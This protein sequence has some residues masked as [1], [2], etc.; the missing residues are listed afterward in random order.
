ML[1]ATA[2]VIPLFK[3][4]NTSPIVG[5][6]LT[7]TLLGPSGLNWVRD[8]HRVDMLGELGIVFFLF[9]MGLEL[10][11]DRLKLMRKDVFGLGTSQ[12]AVT[13]LVGTLIGLY[14]GLSPAAAVTIGGSLALSSS[15]FVLQLLKDKGEMGTRHGRASF[16]ILLLQ[17]LAVVPL[18]IVVELLSKGGAGLGKALGLA[19]IKGC[20]A[21]TTMSYLGRRLLNP[22]FSQVAKSNSQ[23]AFLSIIL[24]TVLLMSFIT[25]GIGL[26][27]TLGAFLAGLLL[28]ETSYKYQIES[29]IA[30]FRGLLL[31]L[32]FITVGFSVDI[33]L[34]YH[35]FPAVMA[36]L[37]AMI[38]TKTTIITA[39]SRWF[40]L[41]FPSALHTGLLTSQGG[42]LGFV[43]F[44]IAEKS[45]MISTQLSKL[46]LTTVA[47]SMAGTP[48]LS[49]LGAGLARKMEANKGEYA[50]LWCSA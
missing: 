17:D 6:M 16:G 3:R 25:H 1:I 11:S 31:G 19:A 4:L 46:L 21:L 45:G 9:E 22:I 8:L 13:T 10:S 42:E 26:S 38:V 44:T 24:A 37:T 41:S 47:L 43:A 40:G 30:P 5:F 36:L 35:Q 34:L 29:D 23:E 15:A 2:I 27:D 20:I 50:V 18:L 12:F 32:F 39:L 49:M 28:S 7:G 48:L 33:R 14:R